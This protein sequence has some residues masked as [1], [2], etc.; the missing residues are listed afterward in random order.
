MT[1]EHGRPFDPGLQVERTLLAWRRTCLA[2]AVGNAVMIR[3][4]VEALGPI[5]AILGVAGLVLSA[6]AWV[7][8]T[9]RYRRAHRGLVDDEVLVLDGTLPLLIAASVGI[10]AVAALLIVVVLWGP[11]Q[12]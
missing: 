10:A 7:L 6:V 8:C 1:A 2:L 5:A 12:P 11:W 9:I 3:Y 4:L